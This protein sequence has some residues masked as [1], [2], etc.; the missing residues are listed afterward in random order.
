MSPKELAQQ[1]EYERALID[2]YDLKTAGLFLMQTLEQTAQTY[3]EASA[4]YASCLHNVGDWHTAKGEYVA[5]EMFLLDVLKRYQDLNPYLNSE[6][7]SVLSSLGSVYIE[8]GRYQDA[9]KCHHKAQQQYEYLSLNRTSAAVAYSAYEISRAYSVMY[10]FDYAM[11]Y[12]EKA[13]FS[14]EKMFGFHHH[15]TA[16][17]YMQMAALH[18]ETGRACM[19]Q[20]LRT[21]EYAVETQEQLSGIN[22]PRTAW[23]YEQLALSCFSIHQKNQGLEYYKQAI[24]RLLGAVGGTHPLYAAMLWRCARCY[25]IY[26]REEVLEML[27]QVLLIYQQIFESGHHFIISLTQEIQALNYDDDFALAF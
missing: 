1:Q 2:A 9:I 6:R 16:L 3:G 26:S 24:Q 15:Q 21:H 18:R 4:E 27:H 17:A 23:A 11:N 20:C 12:A 8:M 14:F 13:A 7:A 10:K 22:H 19:E 25:S 5:A